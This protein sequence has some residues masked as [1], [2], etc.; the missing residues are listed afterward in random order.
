MS[1]FV[2]TAEDYRATY[3]S[4]AVIFSLNLL[5]VMATA[6]IWKATTATPSPSMLGVMLAG[7]SLITKA[8]TLPED[9]HRRMG[10]KG[11]LGFFLGAGFT[12]VVAL[13]FVFDR[14]VDAPW[15]AAHFWYVVM[16]GASMGLIGSI[17]AIKTPRLMKSSDPDRGQAT[18]HGR[19]NQ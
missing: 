18:D 12:T 6:L 8:V 19:E 2:L 13:Q 7:V 14:L 17:V 10:T 3:V 9:T 1:R 11:L 5:L 16:S 15:D 4:G